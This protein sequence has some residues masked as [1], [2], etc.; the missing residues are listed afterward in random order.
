MS[1]CASM[2]DSED[3]GHS[4]AN[5]TARIGSLRETRVL[6]PQTVASHFDL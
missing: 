1:N 6:E 5:R 3:I 2:A 4:L